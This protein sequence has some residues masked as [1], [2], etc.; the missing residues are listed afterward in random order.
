M[1]TASLSPKSAA[2]A[3][4]PYFLGY[5]LIAAFISHSISSPTPASNGRVLVL[6]LSG[7][8]APIS[9]GR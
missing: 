3:E 9:P 8:L 4:D 5:L 2:L 6:T 7:I 1:K